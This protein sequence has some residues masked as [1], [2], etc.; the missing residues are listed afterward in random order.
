MVKDGKLFVGVARLEIHIP[1]ARS[2]KA[3]RSAS[4]LTGLSSVAGALSGSTS[5]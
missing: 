5:A 1:E 2:L 3:K 4:P